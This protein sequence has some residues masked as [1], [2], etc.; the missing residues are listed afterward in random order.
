MESRLPS[1]RNSSV[2][3]LY[4][5]RRC[6]SRRS[7]AVRIGVAVAALLLAGS[8]TLEAGFSL[9]NLF[10]FL[11]FS[12]FSATNSTTRSV[13]LGGPFFQSLGTNGR[14]CGTCHAPSDGFG[15]SAIDAQIR[16]FLTNGKD[17]LFAQVDGST[18]PTGTV[19]NSLVTN[20]GLIRIGLTVPP[21][22]TSAAS[23]QYTITAVQDP[24]G[25]ALTTSSGGTQTASVYR[26]PLP[27]TN[28]GFL[29]AVM[30]D[31]RESFL[32]PLNNAQTF[33]ANLNTDLTQQATDA[34][35]GHAQAKQPP[36]AS[37]L[38]QI[39]SFEL[40]LNS[41]Q[42]SDFFAGNL[43]GQN[44]SLGGPQFLA[45]QQFYPGINDSL[46]GDPEGKQ[47]TPN[48][49]TLYTAW[50]NSSNSQQA[51]INR[52]ETIFNTQPLT[53]SDVPG[54]TAGTG[55]IVGTCTTC[56]DTPNVGNHSFSLPL[57]IGTGH[58]QLYETD[59]NIIAGLQQLQQPTLPVF[60]LVCTQGTEAGQTFYTT[61]PG[62]ALLTG[63]C[64]DIS[65]V[66]GPILRGLASRAPY[67]H[68]GAAANLSQVVNF[69]N[70]RFQMGLSSQQM[71]DL[72]NFLQTL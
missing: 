71:Q 38:S 10:P 57:D 20:N 44:G 3:T 60:Q 48:V 22:S 6:I 4:R 53:I 21:N 49:F 56:H 35:L 31:G 61:D 51:S 43:Y 70:H 27:T 17:P 33:T 24:Y 29:S 40:A 65:R 13:S 5:I 18:C 30:W 12:G 19:N 55:Q 63:Q 46:G 26:R 28:L 47:F 67:F 69:Y 9:P 54:L 68:N 41:A 11:D 37:Q 39:V 52:G 16:Y 42:L 8:T 14:S 1:N 62:K 7:P 15:L 45:T 66:K 23:P 25:C 58:S 36:T 34:T 59:P 50:Q 2:G 72:I 64:T 32:Y